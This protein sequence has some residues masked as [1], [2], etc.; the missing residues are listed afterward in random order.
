[1]L[2]VLVVPEGQLETTL[3]PATLCPGWGPSRWAGAR[4]AIIGADAA[5]GGNGVSSC[6]T[7]NTTGASFLV[8]TLVVGVAAHSAWAIGPYY[9][10][11]NNLHNYYQSCH[12]VGTDT[13]R[14]VAARCG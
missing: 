4:K 2:Y 6:G 3:L 1:M 14:Q 11:P 9:T 13:R 5:S 10:Q 8:C 12:L 7:G